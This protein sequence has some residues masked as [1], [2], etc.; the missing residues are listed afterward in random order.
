[1]SMKSIQKLFSLFA[2]VALILPASIPASAQESGVD[3]RIWTVDSNGN[4]VYDVCYTL[5]EY[6]NLG[7]DENRDGN[8]LFQDVAPGRYYVEPQIIEGGFYYA[9]PFTIL[10]D[11]LHTDHV[12]EAM[13]FRGS[14]S[15]Q[16]TRDVH[17]ITRDPATGEVITDACY[18]FKD[19]SKI[20][21]DENGDGHITY[22][23]I[24]LGDYTIQQ[25]TTPEGYDPMGDYDVSI[26]AGPNDYA[27]PVVILLAQGEEQAPENHYN[28]SVVY[29]DVATGDRVE[30]EDNCIQLF[31]AG[32][33]ITKVGC[34]ED[35]VDG[36]VD[37]MHVDMGPDDT[38]FSIEPAIACP[39]GIAD[40]S[41]FER[42]PTGESSFT[43]YIHLSTT[44][45]DD[46]G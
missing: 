6:S 12:V 39:F 35:V 30:N 36:Q 11:E 18:Q 1:M 19:Y 32:E 33:P 2:L 17:L 40:G 42:R 10:I 23:D 41:Q 46:C 38:M 25:T 20:G 21:C 5:V 34:D 16:E 37:F 26:L 4:P 8:V 7:C 14:G 45:R 13:E 44:V 27:G 15:T 31:K 9:E 24:P 22:A 29:Y 43:L 3:V 28:V